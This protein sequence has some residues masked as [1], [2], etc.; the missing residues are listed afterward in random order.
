MKP[1]PTPSTSVSG[2]LNGAMASGAIDSMDP[3]RWYFAV[4][5]GLANA[6]CTTLLRYQDVSGTAG[7]KLVPGLAELPQVSSN[8]LVVASSD[9]ITA[10][11]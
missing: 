8:G 4:T 11:A 10:T 6:M 3:N 2:T 1:S 7:T 9:T 5:W